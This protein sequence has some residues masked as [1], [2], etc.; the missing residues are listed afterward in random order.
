ME[1]IA[2]NIITSFATRFLFITAILYVNMRFGSLFF[3]RTSIKHVNKSQ[4]IVENAK[5][6]YPTNF[7][8]QLLIKVQVT[9]LYGYYWCSTDLIVSTCVTIQRNNRLYSYQ[10]YKYTRTCTNRLHICGVLHIQAYGKHTPHVEHSKEGAS[11]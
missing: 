5:P 3:K 10:R 1:N 7:N 6:I 8:K 4:N 2:L 9:T 11:S